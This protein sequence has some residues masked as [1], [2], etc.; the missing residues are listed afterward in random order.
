MSREAIERS[1]SVEHFVREK[2]NFRRFATIKLS[3][4]WLGAGHREPRSKTAC[5]AASLPRFEPF[6]CLPR[7][8]VVGATDHD[9]RF[10]NIGEVQ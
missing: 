9:R 6:C 5:S 10:D 1:I 8:R 7:L 3:H 4:K 2:L